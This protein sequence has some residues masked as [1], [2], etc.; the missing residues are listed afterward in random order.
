MQFLELLILIMLP[1]TG[2]IFLLLISGDENRVKVN[3][4]YVGLLISVSTFITS[5]YLCGKIYISGSNL[6][7]VSVYSLKAFNISLKFGMNLLT[8]IFTNVITFLTILS[9][10][11]SKKS[12]KN[13]TREYIFLILILEF[14]SLSVVCARDLFVFF[15]SFFSIS[16]VLFFQISFW[17]I[18]KRVNTANK[19]IIYSLFGNAYLLIAFFIIY[20]QYG[21][22]D[23]SVLENIMFS[24]TTKNL[25]LFLLI[26]SIFFFSPIFPVHLGLIDCFTEAPSPTRILISGIYTKLMLY[27]LFQLGIHLIG[28]E[29]L[30]F[31]SYM[32]AILSISIL[33]CSLLSLTNRDIRRFTGY[34]HLIQN[35]IVLIGFFCLTVEG[36][37]GSL[38]LFVSQAISMS[39]FLIA[40][41]AY[42]DKFGYNFS[43]INLLKKYPILSSLIFLSGLNLIGFPPLPNFLGQFLIL[44]SC[45]RS[46]P[47]IVF[48]VF[49]S[50][51]LLFV[52]FYRIFSPVLLGKE[53]STE[54]EEDDLNCYEKFISMAII[55]GIAFL[56]INPECLF[57]LIRHVV[58]PFFE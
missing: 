10:F 15:I 44:Q 49:V 42:Y 14:F 35:S 52:S 34:L 12:V 3:S 43:E 37:K 58:L 13:H 27:F 46:H 23:F 2:A 54:K 21:S 28:E 48:F 7:T 4:F 17:G 29:L 9:I 32:T 47:V 6:E 36:F 1:F 39:I 51:M 57:C 38:F 56:T 53:N 11:L 8:V 45:Y 30:N 40:M 31:S 25:L 19:F 50:I 33:V 41:G 24:Q 20:Q 18:E 22:S 55:G 5:I 16:F 26:G